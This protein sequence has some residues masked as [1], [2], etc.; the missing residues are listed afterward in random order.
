MHN[1]F[2]CP[3]E[4][5]TSEETLALDTVFSKCNYSKRDARD[6]TGELNASLHR[7]VSPVLLYS[8]DFH[9]L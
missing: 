7:C 8:C 4:G 2:Y 1:I 3:Q 6:H 5:A 9:I